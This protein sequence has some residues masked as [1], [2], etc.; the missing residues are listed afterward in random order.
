MYSRAGA[1]PAQRCERGGL[2]HHSPANHTRYRGKDDGATRT[3]ALDQGRT[4]QKEYND[5]GGDRF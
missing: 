1:G 4:D 2:R 5:L 3:N